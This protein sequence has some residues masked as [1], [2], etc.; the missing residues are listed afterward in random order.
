MYRV[1]IFAGIV[2]LYLSSV[3]Q[4]FNLAPLPNVIINGPINDARGIGKGDEKYSAYFGYTIVLRETSVLIG[5]PRAVTAQPDNTS[6]ET[7]II[8]KY[9]LRAKELKP[10]ELENNVTFETF[11]G[12][13]Q[14]KSRQWLGGAMDGGSRDADPLIACAP[15]QTA[16]KINNGGFMHG[17][18]YWTNNTLHAEKQNRISWI[19]SPFA[20]K[21]EH[22]KQENEN[23]KYSFLRYGQYGFSILLTANNKTVIAGAPGLLN[24]EGKVI[25]FD[26]QNKKSHRTKTHTSAPKP[27]YKGYAVGYG[28]FNA[29]D[30]QQMSYVA[31]A[32]KGRVQIYTDAKRWSQNMFPMQTGY[33]GTQYGEF[34]GYSLLVED[35]NGDGLDDILVSAPHRIV[36]NIFEAG[37][38]H[39]H[40][41]QG[42][43]NQLNFERSLLESPF[44]SSGHFGTALSKL[45]DI[46]KDGYKD[47][48]ISAPFAGSQRH[49]AVA[50]YFGGPNG[51]ETQPRQILNVSVDYLGTG[52]EGFFGQALSKG[53]DIDGNDYNDLAVGAPNADKV[54]IYRTYPVV[55]INATM[56]PRNL[57]IPT[58]ET[59]LRLEFCINILSNSTKVKKQDISV[60]LSAGDK[61]ERINV[62]HCFRD[63]LLSADF[64]SK[65]YICN[66]PLKYDERFMFVPIILELSYRLKNDGSRLNSS[67]FCEDC[68][69]VDPGWPSLAQSHI[70]YLH[71]CQG[72]VCN[73][74]LRLQSVNMPK[75]LT[76]GTD[77]ILPLRYNITNVGEE[78]YY[79]MLTITFSINVPFAKMPAEC[80]QDFDYGMTVKCN[81]AKRR[82]FTNATVVELSLDLSNV[83]GYTVLNISASVFSTG[84]EQ[85]PADNEVFDQITLFTSAEIW[86]TET[87]SNKIASVTD[88]HQIMPVS[89]SFEI[90]NAGPSPLSFYHLVIDFPIGYDDTKYISNY[91]AQAL[92][93]GLEYPISEFVTSAPVSSPT[94]N[95]SE[96]LHQN[97]ILGNHTTILI[98]E[99]NEESKL[100]MLC[101][102]SDIQLPKV[103]FAGENLT[104]VLNFDLNWE[105]V[106]EAL[107]SEAHEYLAHI[108]RVSVKPNTPV[109]GNLNVKHHYK[110][111]VFMKISKRNALWIY[112]SAII[113][114]I[115]LLVAV[116]LL[117]RRYGF[118]K[119][120]T[121]EEMEKNFNEKQE[122][123]RMKEDLDVCFA[124]IEEEKTASS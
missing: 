44:P 77:K 40:I 90:Q 111:S 110:G 1:E 45:G 97:H 67:E 4:S 54:F 94:L 66:A 3:V 20:A 108:A 34:Y 52:G 76:L 124:E 9:D 80:V 74:D 29:S 115:L 82:A 32:P 105:N 95:N 92:F 79:T 18:C 122:K 119:R 35:L 101:A 96:I 48:A 121:K 6:V 62:T 83:V 112:I 51:L 26:L 86:V 21:G 14:S 42:N 13:Q 43:A 75:S 55:K 12:L 91:S 19:L 61:E 71:N 120:L 30:P 104:L 88:D 10:F 5:A 28:Y 33:Y 116:V 93:K 103:L 69:I 100:K 25:H 7:G 85:R 87:S 70:Q 39:M 107:L 109:N 49:G 64:E 56:E 117:L 22:D 57:I 50:I 46:N 31:S 36:N 72:S 106:G 41:N 8:Y 114:G 17:A 81:L 59:L 11:Y 23:L 24:W 47:V 99:I 113:G 38:V 84:V 73:V 16:T 78:A 27:Q 102:Q 53:V 118:F 65:C 89:T 2:Y 123:A 60:D 63:E 58:N 98:C 68:A 15:L 37:A